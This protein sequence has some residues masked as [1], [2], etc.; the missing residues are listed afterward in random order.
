METEKSVSTFKRDLE[1]MSTETLLERQ[2][3]WELRIEDLLAQR[4]K[5][6]GAVDTID[7]MLGCYSDELQKRDV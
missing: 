7:Q 2:K 1:N 6:D 4:E 5:I 3:L